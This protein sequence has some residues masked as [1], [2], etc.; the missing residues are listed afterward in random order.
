MNNQPL[1]ETYRTQID[2]LVDRPVNFDLNQR[3]QYTEAN[4]WH[5]DS[6][7][8]D[9]PPEAPGEP[10]P[11]GSWEIARQMMREYRFPDPSIITGIYYPDRPLEKRVMLL[12]GRFLWFTFLFGVRIGG[13][14]DEVRETKDGPERV[15]GFNYQTLEGH[16]ERGQMDFEVV[17]WLHTGQVGFHIHAFSQAATIKNPF[18]RL[19]FRLFGRGLQRRF[20]HRSLERMQELVKQGLTKGIDEARHEVESPTV[21]PASA[22]EKTDEKIKEVGAKS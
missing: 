9:L 13:V 16:F 15:W 19:G 4:G 12:R 11:N 2:A 6:Y 20:A 7:Q 18:Y 5:I 8:A 21:R 3:E 14:V 10:V 22:E 1:W 17:K